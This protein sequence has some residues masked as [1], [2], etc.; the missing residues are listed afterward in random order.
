[1]KKCK[2]NT[3]DDTYVFALQ[4]RNGRFS[5]SLADILKCILKAEKQGILPGLPEELKN[6]L[7]EIAEYEGDT[8]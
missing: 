2:P 4:D 3:E 7:R 6:R 1:M 8:L 5:I